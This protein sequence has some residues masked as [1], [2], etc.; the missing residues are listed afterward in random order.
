MENF[1]DYSVIHIFIIH[2][3]NKS[4]LCIWLWYDNIS[5]EKCNITSKYYINA[6]YSENVISLFGTVQCVDI[7]FKDYVRYRRIVIIKKKDKQIVIY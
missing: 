3:E 2:L 5:L 6:L 7:V 1:W 4:I